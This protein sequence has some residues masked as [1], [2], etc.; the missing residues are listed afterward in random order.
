M[1]FAVKMNDRYCLKSNSEILER[2]NLEIS[3]VS[4]GAFWLIRHCQNEPV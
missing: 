2:L 1:D 3:T 4:D